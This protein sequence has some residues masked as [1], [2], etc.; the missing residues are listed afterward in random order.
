MAVRRKGT[1][2][3]VVDG[4]SFRWRVSSKG[5]A[6]SGKI[7]LAIHCEAGPG[8]GIAVHVPCRD[9]YLDLH[10]IDAKDLTFDSDSYRPV[11]PADIRAIILAAL[12]NG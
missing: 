3:I 8:P 9:F 11:K 1:R 2:S 6:E 5:Q 10:D 4:L 7:L 12:E